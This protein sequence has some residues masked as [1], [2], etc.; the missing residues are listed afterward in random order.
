[1]RQ[2]P[3]FVGVDVSKEGLDVAVR[4]GG[5]QW[6][7]ANDAAGVKRLVKRLQELNCMRIVVEATGGYETLLVSALWTQGLPVVLVNP[8]WVRAFARPGQLA[9]TDA[10]DARILALYAERAELKVREL[11]ND[12][13]RHARAVRT[14]RRPAGH[15]DR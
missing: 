10:I 6:S 8:R 12:E 2:Q 1:M 11:P 15:A 14:A 4:P 7:E 5:E 13:L 3:V 9:K